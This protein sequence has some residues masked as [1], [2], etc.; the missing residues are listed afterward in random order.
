MDKKKIYLI[1]LYLIGAIVDA[2]GA[3]RMLA[4]MVTS[5]DNGLV[6]EMVGL[7]A[8]LDAGFTA[9]LIWAALKPIERRAALLITVV[10]IVGSVL[11]SAYIY[12]VAP[13]SLL[14][15]VYQF[16]GGALLAGFYLHGYFYAGKETRV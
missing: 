13:F 7:G 15:F 1:I 2:V 8:V 5:L 11:V 4:Y 3:I 16:V 10:P 14:E 9:L 6:R 12:T